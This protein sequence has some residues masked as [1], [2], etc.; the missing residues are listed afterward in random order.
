MKHLLN[1]LSE[2]E[3]NNIREQHAGGMKVSN[4]R[5][6]TLLETKSG[7]VKP[8]ISEQGEVTQKSNIDQKIADGYRKVSEVSL[9]DGKYVMEGSADICFI[10]DQDGKTETGYIVEMPMSIRGMWSPESIEVKNKAFVGQH[11]FKSIIFK[12][13]GYVPKPQTE[14]EIKTITNNVASEGIKNVTSQMMSDPPFKGWYSGYEFGGVFGGISYEWV[15][16][17]VAGMSGVRGMVDGQVLSETLENMVPSQNLQITDGK[18][19]LPCVGFYEDNGSGFLIYT[20]TDGTPK[21]KNF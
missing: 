14:T 12:N 2:E 15:C 21:C 6:N 1:D 5:F 11:E 17:G 3:K 16:N 4:A 19:G 7:D 13:V 8:L 18:P 20:S 9:P 10:Y